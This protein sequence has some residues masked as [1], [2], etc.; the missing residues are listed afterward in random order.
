LPPRLALRHHAPVA[1]SLCELYSTLEA[2]GDY[3]LRDAHAALDSTVRAT[4]GMKEGEDTL[5]FSVDYPSN[6][7]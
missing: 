4:Y 7:A 1:R 2:P 6:A 5:A 3:H